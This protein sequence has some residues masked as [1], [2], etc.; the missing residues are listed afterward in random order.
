MV[1]GIFQQVEYF[2]IHGVVNDPNWNLI[3]TGG[4][5]QKVKIFK[6]PVLVPKQ[7]YKEYIG[8]SSHITRVRFSEDEDYLLSTGG[9]DRT[10]LL[11]EVERPNKEKKAPKQL[12][13]EK[14]K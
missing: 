11:W 6:Y 10:S 1:Q 7:K 8:H 14:N 2:S 4:T 3:A 12:E 5:D 13:Q 9:N